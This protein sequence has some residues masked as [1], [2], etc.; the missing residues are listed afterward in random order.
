MGLEKRRGIRSD[1]RE[2]NDELLTVMYLIWKW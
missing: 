2:S 1:T